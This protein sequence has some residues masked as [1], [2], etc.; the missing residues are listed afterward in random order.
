[1][2]HSVILQHRCKEYMV[3]SLHVEACAS[4]HDAQQTICAV[5]RQSGLYAEIVSFRPT[6]VCT[7]VQQHRM[8]FFNSARDSL[9]HFV[10]STADKFPFTRWNIQANNA[11]PK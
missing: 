4:L 1:M 2:V 10:S 11:S 6:S 3:D 5:D 9:R 8:R 7:G